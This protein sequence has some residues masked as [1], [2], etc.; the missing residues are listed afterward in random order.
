MS[1]LF[2][3]KLLLIFAFFTAGVFLYQYSPFISLLLF[4]LSILSLKFSKKRAIVLILSALMFFAGGMYTLLTEY[5]SYTKAD[6]AIGKECEIK[7][8]LISIP[9]TETYGQSAVC[10]TEYGK[11]RLMTS[12]PILKYKDEITFRAKCYYPGE[13]SRKL[14]FDYPLYLKSEGIYLLAFAEEVT[15]NSSTLSLLNPVDA[16]TYLRSV[17]AQK[18]ATLW[19]GETLMFANSILLGDTSLSSNE[20]KEKLAEGS[21]S[22]II[23]VSGTHVSLI[24]AMFMVITETF[25]KRK[26]YLYLLSVPFIMAFV[27]LTGISPSAVRAAVMM[28]L[29]LI[30]KTTLS[31]YDSLTALFFSAFL[32]LLFNPFSAFSLSFIL[33]FS[34]VLG[35][36]LFAKPIADILSFLHIGFISNLLA[37][38]LSA[39]VFTIITLCFSF[40]RFPFTALL[41]NIIAVP[42]IP[43]VMASGYIALAISFIFPQFDIISYIA[44]ILID[45]CISIA[46]L[47][48]RLPFANIYPVFGNLFLSVSIFSLISLLAASI[49]I[50]RKR[51]YSVILSLLLI[52]ALIFN[53]SYTF[54]AG[55][56]S[57]YFVDAGHGDST[58]VLNK[59][60]AILIDCLSPEDRFVKDT[61]LP[62][63]RYH[64]HA[65]IDAVFLSEY[66]PYDEDIKELIESFPVNAVYLPEKANSEDL[67][68]A[69]RSFDT[70]IFF[71]KENDSI[72]T[73][74]IVVNVP[75]SF[76]RTCSFTVTNNGFNVLFPGN[77]T[78]AKEKQLAKKVSDVDIL[79]A[80]RHGNKGSCSITLLKATTP[81][82]VIVSSRYALSENFSHRLSSFSVYS[83]KANGDIKVNAESKKITPYKK[84]K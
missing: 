7:G 25:A 23:A 49:L 29:Y 5:I 16:I 52:V 75:Y 64:G 70:K 59:D 54:I 1:S 74:D 33:S 30:A 80:P 37:V 62:I 84:V 58:I 11:I 17:L 12:K 34:A 83:T 69:A 2:N 18:A 67:R 61:L 56:K 4:P 72:K 35:I 27:L 55:E 78:E 44:E 57:F 76:R 36:L 51:K 53:N 48:G 31:H 38:T 24:A 6:A 20:F 77:I 15:V 22:H 14:C 10:L 79:K 28:I 73:G 13:K 63:L 81:E 32:I 46:D 47:A 40:G 21:I 65:D 39:Q 9:E 3:R 19:T 43:F 82:A 71:L 45:I 41:A 26:R 68:K 66:D 42:F 50:L 60:T 8:V